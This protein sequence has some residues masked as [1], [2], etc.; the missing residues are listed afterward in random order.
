MSA[1]VAPTRIVSPSIAYNPDVKNGYS[2]S[3][4]R[5]S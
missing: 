5:R 4:G 2:Y 1:A 3:Q